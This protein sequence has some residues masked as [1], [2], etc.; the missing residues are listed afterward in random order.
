MLYDA[1][2]TYGFQGYI[3]E[4]VIQTAAVG[5]GQLAAQFGYLGNK[6]GIAV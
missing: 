5:S 3:A 2:G 1:T 4:I 6:Y